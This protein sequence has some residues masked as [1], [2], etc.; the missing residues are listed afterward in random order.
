A[1]DLSTVDDLSVLA[2]K[3]ITKSSA[4]RDNVNRVTDR[5]SARNPQVVTLSTLRE[6][7]R[8]FADSDAVDSAE[9]EGLA[10]VAAQFYDLLADVRP[11]LGPLA[12]AER[13]RI[14]RDKLVDSAVMMHGYVELMK[15]FQL[16]LGQMGTQ[17]GERHWKERLNRLS[18]RRKYKMGG[19]EG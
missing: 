14:R 1:Y 15:E 11:E 16:A 19:W 13:Q 5:L 2:K 7:M 8:A 17:R 10:E 3:F 9:L 6:M 12:L 18:S 4:L